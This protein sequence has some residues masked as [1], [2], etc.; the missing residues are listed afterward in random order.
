MEPTKQLSLLSNAISLAIA[1]G[2]TINQ[3]REIADKEFFEQ[4]LDL[5]K[6]NRTKAAASLGMHRNTVMRT[7]A[8]LKIDVRSITQK[9]RPS[10]YRKPV[11]SVGPNLTVKHA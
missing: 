10:R 4:S 1:A 9:H 6:G 11:G 5:T 8:E 2:L 3:F 7:I